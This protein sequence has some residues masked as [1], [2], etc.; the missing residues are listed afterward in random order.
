M[1]YGSWMLEFYSEVHSILGYHLETL[2]KLRGK[3]VGERLCH[4]VEYILCSV[5]H[6]LFWTATL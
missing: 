1:L 3:A 2:L 4:L 6:K 5:L